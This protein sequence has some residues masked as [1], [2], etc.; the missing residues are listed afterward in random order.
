MAPLSPC[1][2][3]EDLLGAGTQIL[4]C[5]LAS[6]DVYFY[7]VDEPVVEVEVPSEPSVVIKRLRSSSSTFHFKTSGTTGIPKLVR[8]PVQTLLKGVRRSEELDRAVWGYCYSTRHISGVLLLLQAWLTDTPVV[9]LRSIGKDVLV[10]CMRT[11][12][13]THIS[14]PA[15]FYRLA[16]PLSSPVHSVVKVSNGGEP[17]DANFVD[18]V[19]VS[20]PNAEIRNVYASTEFGS[21]LVAKGHTFRIPDR[22][23]DVVRVEGNTI[24]V[25]RDRMASSVVFEG[26]WYDTADQVEWVDDDRFT[27]KGRVSEQVKVLGHLISL[28]KV[29]AAINDIEGVQISR[30]QASKHAVF[31][32]LL[33]AEVVLEDGVSMTKKEIKTSLSQVLRDYEVPAR[34]KLVDAIETTYTGK[35]ARRRL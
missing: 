20:F 18:R 31:G 24:R 5:L 10:D 14:A 23:K 8:Q 29:E 33:S 16:C 15:T 13:V 22:L 28:R 35:L 30:L 27:I 32:T 12:D 25:H 7:D 34:I 2:V 26:E 21:L 11:H 17:L 3:D 9:D 6:R 4:A 1:I 19:Q